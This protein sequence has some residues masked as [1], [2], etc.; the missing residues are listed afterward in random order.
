MLAAATFANG[1]R[2][3]ADALVARKRQWVE[4]EKTTQN[5]GERHREIA[6]AN[7]ALQPLL[8]AER[9]RLERQI[10][11]AVQRSRANRVLESRE[12]AFCL[13]PSQSLADFFLDF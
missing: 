8:A 4:T 13:F 11:A 1:E 6:A 9:L 2:L 12:F 5:A 10:D 7:A 3:A